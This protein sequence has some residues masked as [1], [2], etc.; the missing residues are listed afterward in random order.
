MFSDPC[1]VE[2]V[3][4]YVGGHINDQSD[5]QG[6]RFHSLSTV[7]GHQDR[8]IEALCLQTQELS[9]KFHRLLWDHIALIQHVWAIQNTIAVD[10]FFRPILPVPF[11]LTLVGI[12]GS[13]SDSSSQPSDNSDT[14]SSP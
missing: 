11:I 12:N 5:L 8:E 3:F 10:L 6:A 1:V 9:V 14:E 13:G 7:N 2:R 4:D